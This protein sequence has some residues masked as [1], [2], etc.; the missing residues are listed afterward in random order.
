MEKKIKKILSIIKQLK[1]NGEY[2]SY[3]GE[4]ISDIEDLVLSLNKE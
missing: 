4:L 2:W 3:E 1:K